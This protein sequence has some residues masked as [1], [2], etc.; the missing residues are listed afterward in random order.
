MPEFDTPE[1]LRTSTSKLF[2]R[3]KKLSQAGVQSFRRRVVPT[4]FLSSH[5]KKREAT[6]TPGITPTTDTTK[7]WRKAYVI[8]CSIL[9]HTTSL[10][11]MSD[12]VRCC[13]TPPQDFRRPDLNSAILPDVVLSLKNSIGRECPLDLSSAR[14]LIG[15]CWEVMMLCQLI[16]CTDLLVEPE[17]R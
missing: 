13:K 15:H 3:A 5:D 6:M 7:C 12:A 4:H 14:S 11:V 9:L 1:I 10:R 2:L 17:T 16:F 8:S